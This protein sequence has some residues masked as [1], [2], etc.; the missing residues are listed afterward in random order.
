VGA[1]AHLHNGGGRILIGGACRVHGMV[2][3][4]RASN[5][6]KTKTKNSNERELVIDSSHRCAES[7]DFAAT[8]DNWHFYGADA[9]F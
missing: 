3:A 2:Q 5:G 7:E 1:A 6:A 4:L 8:T 9:M